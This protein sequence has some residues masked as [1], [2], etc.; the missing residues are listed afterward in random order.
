MRYIGNKENLTNRIYCEIEK[1]NIKCKTFFDVFS[2]TANVAKYFK[3][4][5]YQIYSNDLMYYSFVLQKAYIENNQIPNFSK[6]LNLI[7]NKVNVLFAE[8]LQIIL[9]Y[10]ENLPPKQGFFYNNYSPS[11][12]KKLDIPRMYFTDENAKFIDKTRIKIQEWKDDNII[13]E[14]EFFIL[15]A[16]LIETVPFY[17]NISGTYGAFHKKWDNRALKKIYLRQPE[18]IINNYKNLCFNTNSNLLLNEISADIFYLD[19]PYNQ[20]QYAPNYHILE[21]IAKYDNPK[22]KGISGIREYENQKS[23]F[24]NVKTALQDLEEIAKYGKY[25]YLLL[26]YNNEGIMPQNSIIEILKSLGNLELVEFDYL[27]FKSNSNGNAK[28]KKFI[29]EQLYI[30]EKK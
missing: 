21:T 5:N 22:I 1:R 9:H 25:K 30:L 4:K 14:L 26:S 11:G 12:S 7:Q 6:C 15:C 19:P 16:S 13:T 8:P 18:I 3:R 2:G 29:K 23:R 24:C 28:H 27:R 20:R 17:S 10:L